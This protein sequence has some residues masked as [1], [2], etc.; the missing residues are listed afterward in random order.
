[1]T[2]V[3]AALLN[4]M[5]ME[6]LRL[7]QWSTMWVSLQPCEKISAASKGHTMNAHLTQMHSVPTSV[8]VQSCVVSVIQWADFAGESHVREKLEKLLGLDVFNMATGVVN[9]IRCRGLCRW[10]GHAVPSTE[11]CTVTI[12]SCGGATRMGVELTAAV[13]IFLPHSFKK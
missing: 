8:F 7:L 1:M 11:V 13:M 4:E 12:A 6:W 9:S 2:N 10:S 3:M 5:L